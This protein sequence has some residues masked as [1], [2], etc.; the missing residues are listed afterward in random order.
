MFHLYGLLIGV[1]ITS[2]IFVIQK[3][4]IHFKKDPNIIEE[5]LLWIAIPAVVGARAYHVVTDWQLYANGPLIDILKVWNGGLGFF[6]A[7]L[8]GLLGLIAFAHFSSVKK[9]SIFHFPFSFFF[10]LLD[11][12][13]FGVP[14]AQAIGR[15]GNYFNQELYGLP[16]HLP[17]G[18]VINGEK[19]HPLFAYEAVLNLI[20][21]GILN[22]LGWKQKLKLGKGQYACLY[23]ACY[24]LIRFW[25]EFL[26]TQTARWDGAMGVFSIAQ[27]VSLSVS[28]VA[29]TIF[30]LRRH[31]DRGIEWELKTIL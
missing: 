31:A 11:L 19:Y 13:S 21:F 12:L 27:W 23:L 28:L 14:L 29:L 4:T 7:L 8:G 10:L 18:I 2:G 26:R 24:G 20:V 6:G 3:Q 5:S 30:W 25:L 17:W 22:W 1:G 9:F 16:T 15:L